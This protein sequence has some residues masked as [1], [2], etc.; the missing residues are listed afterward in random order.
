MGRIKINDLPRDV[1][2]THGEMRKVLGGGITVGLNNLSVVHKGSSGITSAFPDVCSTPSPG[3][4]IP[5][6]YPNIGLAS[7]TTGGSK[8][9]K[10]GGGVAATSS[11]LSPVTGDE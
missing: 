11:S 5:I 1:H 8:K 9:V 10:I 3:G 4:F 2:I 6:P 7:D